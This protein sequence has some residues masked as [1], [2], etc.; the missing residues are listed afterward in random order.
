MGCIAGVECVTG[1]VKF[2]FTDVSLYLCTKII[3]SVDDLWA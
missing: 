1:C 2:E 3:P